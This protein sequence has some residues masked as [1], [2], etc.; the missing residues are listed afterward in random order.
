MPSVVK[1]SIGTIA[2][3]SSAVI[4]KRATFS[5]PRALPATS[6]ANRHE[7]WRK[8]QVALRHGRD[9]A[10]TEIAFTF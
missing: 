2:A 4:P 8:E 9:T 5:G 7:E 6:S 3:T 10:L 1:G